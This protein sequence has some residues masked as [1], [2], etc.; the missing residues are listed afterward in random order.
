M[1]LFIPRPVLGFILVL[2]PNASY[3]EEI[4]ER[5]KAMSVYHGKGEDEPTIWFSQSI[6]N[7]CGLYAILHALSNGIDRSKI[8]SGSPLDDLLTKSIPLEPYERAL[9]LEASAEIEHAHTSA[10]KKG[11]SR[12]P[13]PNDEIVHHYICFV[14]SP[15]DGHVYE[16]NGTSKG[17]VCHASTVAESDDL[18]EG[19]ALDLIKHYIELAG[20][21]VGFSLLGLTL[22]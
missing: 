16:M 2:P 17:P 14:K 5:E 4:V 9:A 19:G 7:A 21:D 11:I 15:K 8:R 3:D 22:S 12:V 10:A 13:D 20:G 6:H 1:L 18:L